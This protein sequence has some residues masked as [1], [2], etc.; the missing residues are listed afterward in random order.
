VSPKRVRFTTTEAPPLADP[1]PGLGPVVF[2]V[3][4]V[5]R[6][7]EEV[8]DLSDLGHPRLVRP[9]ASALIAE[10]GTRG[11]VRQRQLLQRAVLVVREFVTFA[12][13]AMADHQ[14]VDLDD[15][16]P[17][18]LDAFEQALVTRADAS[19]TASAL[20]VATLR[21]MLRLVDEAQPGRFEGSSLACV[22]RFVA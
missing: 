12:S 3:P 16:E 5:A 15:L 17:E 13:A 8:V 22:G 18:L 6:G 9:L 19:R 4:L 10:V 21:R 2:S 14:E 1:V 7:T 20:T 11:G